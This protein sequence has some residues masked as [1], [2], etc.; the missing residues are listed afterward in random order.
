MKSGCD[1]F[2]EQ[3]TRTV[4][5]VPC[6]STATGIDNSSSLVKT[7]IGQVVCTIENT[8]QKPHESVIS[9]YTSHLNGKKGGL[10]Q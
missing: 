10:L 3:G 9:I 4:L 1:P 2:A 7:Y 5:G 6:N 8:C